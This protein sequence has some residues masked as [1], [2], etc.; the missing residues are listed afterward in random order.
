M[1]FVRPAKYVE[2]VMS[3]VL[4]PGLPEMAL[5]DDELD[6]IKDGTYTVDYRR[7]LII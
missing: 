5:K 6:A 4:Q 7:Y 3:C 2:E 1:I